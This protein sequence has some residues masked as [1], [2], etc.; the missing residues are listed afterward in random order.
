MA[1]SIQSNGDLCFTDRPALQP[2]TSLITSARERAEVLRHLKQLY[3]I[4]RGAYG[5]FTFP[6]GQPVSIERADL[7]KLSADHMISL[8]SDGMRYLLLLLLIDDEPRAVFVSRSLEMFETEV[9]APESYYTVEGGTLFDGELVHEQRG[10]GGM[11]KLFLIFDVVAVRG[12]TKTLLF[13]ER[14]NKIHRHVLSELPAGLTTESELVDSFV[15]DEDRVFLASPDMRMRPKRFVK[16]EDGLRLWRDRRMLNHKNDG[17]ILMGN[18]QLQTHTDRSCFKWKPPELITVDVITDAVGRLYV[19]KRGTLTRVDALTLLGRPRD[20]VVH[21]NE[22]VQ[23]VGLGAST[24]VFECS[25]DIGDDLIAFTP[26]K[27]RPDK[28]CA[29]DFVTVVKTL[30]NVIE[31][32]SVDE[33]FFSSDCTLADSQGQAISDPPPSSGPSSTPNNADDSERFCGAKRRHIRD[34]SPGGGCYAGP[35]ETGGP[36]RSLRQSKKVSGRR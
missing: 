26:I 28:P 14:L 17:L 9:W 27:S 8:K 11:T 16:F 10:D 30:E 25:C 24:T 6:G 29:N 15:L 36:R 31:S 3:G 12:S 34:E 20:V 32:I 5:R 2:S 22:L 33:L 4:R 13:Q 7:P 23:C 1:S 19:Q 21:L 35:A 18:N